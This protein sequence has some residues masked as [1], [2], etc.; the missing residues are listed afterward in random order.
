M[1]PRIAYPRGVIGRFD[2]GRRTAAGPRGLGAGAGAL[3][4]VVAALAWTPGCGY[5]ECG[6]VKL[7]TVAIDE[8]YDEDRDHYLDLIEGCG[9][10][11]GAFGQSFPD[12]QI[13]SILF[14]NSSWE[15]EEI[16]D[17]AYDYLPSA[18][19]AFKAEHLREGTVL[20]IVNMAAVGYHIPSGDSQALRS[21]FEL[22]EGRIEV[23]AGPK[24]D[25]FEGVN[26]KLRWRFTFGEVSEAAPKGMQVWSG[27]DW[28]NFADALWAWDPAGHP[29]PPADAS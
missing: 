25:D 20:E 28:V 27:E 12:A 9:E 14:D 7:W 3:L 22:V 10:D 18:E 5:R 29:W 6:Q 1:A 8:A 11:V 19:V 2:G 24:V 26:W 13:V 23:L 15:E 21:Q 4:T 16:V 17:V